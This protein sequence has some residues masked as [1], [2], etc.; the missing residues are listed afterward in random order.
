MKVSLL[1]MDRLPH[2][3]YLQLMT[4]GKLP[5]PFGTGALIVAILTSGLLAGV[6]Y[7]YAI[8]V[9]PAL[10]AFDDRTFVDVMNKINVVIVNPPFMLS[11]LGSVGFTLLAGA[12]YL[13]PAARPVLVIIGI[14]LALNITS[15]VITSAINVPLNNQ[16]STATT[17]T[18]PTDLSALRQQFESSWVRWNVIRALANTAA[19][20]MLAW[21]LTLAARN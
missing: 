3:G 13:K 15:L 7:S 5:Q 20:A 1:A 21:A 16:L 9:M 19:T 4:L 17:A 10:G 6:Y 8:S 14:G 11:F 2:V 12:W 18:T